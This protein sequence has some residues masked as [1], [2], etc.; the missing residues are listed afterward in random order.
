MLHLAMSE[1]S[2]P[3]GVQTLAEQQNVS[4]T[5]L[6]KILTKLVKEGM[7]SSASGANGG[8]SLTSG[9][10]SI[11][12]LDIIYA[13]EGKSSLFECGLDH[14]SQC[15]IQKVMLDSEEKME[16]ELRRLTLADLVKAS[17]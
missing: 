14:G 11:S 10:E 2:K 16:K 7:V 3:I 15:L 4:P 8:Y 1:S 5:Y 17:K 6:S 12:F 13:I 9:W